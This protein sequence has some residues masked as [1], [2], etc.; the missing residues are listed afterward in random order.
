[1]DLMKGK[2]LENS[3]IT[4]LIKQQEQTLFESQVSWGRLEMKKQTLDQ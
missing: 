3:I 1:M 4:G 2:A